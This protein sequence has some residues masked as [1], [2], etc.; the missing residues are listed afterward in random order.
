MSTWVLL[1]G[2]T[3]ESGHWGR[4]PEQLRA[5]LPG[6][7]V[8]TLDL[9]GSGRWHGSPCPARIGALVDDCR[10]QLDALGARRPIHLL[11]LSLG[12]MVA[13]DWAHHWPDELAG[14]VLINTSLRPLSPFYPRLRPA[15]YPAL[16]RLALLPHGAREREAAILRL[17]SAR[18]LA[19]TAVIDDWVAIRQARPVSATNALRQLWAAARYRAPSYP[20]EV[21]M[22]LL[23]SERDSLVDPC[24]SQRLARAWGLPIALHPSAG[25]DLPLDDGPWLAEQVRCWAEAPA[26]QTR[27]ARGA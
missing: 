27:P 11:A 12:A 8:V 16:L 1:R 19:L 13:V 5:C 26:Q 24:C 2:L 6:A 9:P 23:A 22:L 14:C 10:Q 4:F 3:R 25:H 15:N 21:P 17:T 20:P 18:A 7:S